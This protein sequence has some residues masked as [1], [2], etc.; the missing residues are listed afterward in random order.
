MNSNKERLGEKGN[1]L[2]LILIAVALFA[3]LSYAVTQSTRSGGGSTE[4]EKA[5]LSSA[6]MTQGPT[7]MRTALIR[8]VLG[9]V[10]VSDLLFNTPADFGLASENSLLVFHPAGGGAVYQQAPA[11]LMVGSNNGTWFYNAN[12]DIPEIGTDGAGGNDIIA[13]LPGITQAVCRQ[14]N[15]EFAINTTGCTMT[16]G[17]PNLDSGSDETKVRDNLDS[18]SSGFPS[19]DQDDLQGD[20]C[21]AFTGQPSGCFYSADNGG[22]YVF[23]SVLLER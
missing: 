15:E 2:F 13:F 6:S 4:K 17:V 10:D 23:Y 19:S 20:G 5:I 9:G 8:M 11:D 3:A 12:F 21:T 1:V 16:G 7:A 18:N 14:V 22:E